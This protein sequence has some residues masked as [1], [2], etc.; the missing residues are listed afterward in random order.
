MSKEFDYRQVYADVDEGGGVIYPIRLKEREPSQL[1]VLVVPELSKVGRRKEL[2]ECVSNLL[3]QIT[4]SLSKNCKYASDV[5]ED[6]LNIEMTHALRELGNL[7]QYIVNSSSFN[8]DYVKGF[9]AMEF[10]NRLEA[11]NNLFYQGCQ[12][13]WRHM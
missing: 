4:N 5:T 2:L 9:D 11:I 7:M 8:S 1:E 10:E 12:G 13:L 3:C 6:G